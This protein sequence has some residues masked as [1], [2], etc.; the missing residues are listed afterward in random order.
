MNKKLLFLSIWLLTILLGPITV[1]LNASRIGIPLNTL[2]IVNLIQRLA[3]LLAFTLI[4]WQIVLGAFM[5]KWEKYLGNWVFKFHLTQGAI[6]YSLIFL[7]PISLLFFIF[8]ARGVID[9]FYIF[10]DFCVLCQTKPELYYTFG[11][12][13]FWLVSAAILAATVRKLPWWR[14][15]WRKFHILNYLV[16]FLIGVH[17]WFIGSDTSNFPFVIF[18]LATIPMVSVIAISKIVVFLK[19]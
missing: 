1:I 6:A 10:T 3:G 9:P 14:Q 16:F 7:H 13:S 12:I 18:F 2:L 5:E 4:F 15:N 11:R 19:S 8:I 17:A